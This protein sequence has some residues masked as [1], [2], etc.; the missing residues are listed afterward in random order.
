M[1]QFRKF[2][3]ILENMQRG[4]HWKIFFFSFLFNK[5]FYSVIPNE[6]IRMPFRGLTMTKICK[7]AKKWGLCYRFAMVSLGGFTLGWPSCIYEHFQTVPP[8]KIVVPFSEYILFLSM[9]QLKNSTDGGHRHQTYE[10]R[11][12]FTVFNE[13]P[14]RTNNIQM[15]SK[16]WTAAS[17]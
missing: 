14:F 5:V 8:P 17:E 7:L 11:A 9:S 12:L 4:D 10:C 16:I 1:S 6:T 3:K 15:T 13:K 2:F